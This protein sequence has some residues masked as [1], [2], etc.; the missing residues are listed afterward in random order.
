MSVL[1]V[2]GRKCTLT[3]SRAAPWWLTL[4]MRRAPY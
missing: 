4:N 2:L 3:A 1:V